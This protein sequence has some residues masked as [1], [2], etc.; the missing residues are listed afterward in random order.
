MGISIDKEIYRSLMQTTIE[1]WDNTSL[2]QN[3][4]EL[5]KAIENMR[6]GL[7]IVKAL[8]VKEDVS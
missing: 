3:N 1:A 4:P 7:E 8:E 2:R 6:Y 5:Q